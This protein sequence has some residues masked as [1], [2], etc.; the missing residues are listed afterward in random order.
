MR[1]KMGQFEENFI[2]V[3]MS[4]WVLMRMVDRECVAPVL[5]YTHTLAL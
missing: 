4:P 5:L 3:S 2:S 1:K